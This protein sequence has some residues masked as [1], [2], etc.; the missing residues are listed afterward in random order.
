[1][2]NLSLSIKRNEKIVIVGLSGSGKST[3]IKLLLRLYEP[4]KGSVTIDGKSIY[5][6]SRT[7]LRSLITVVLQD[8]ELFN[9]SFQDNIFLTGKTRNLILFNEAVAKSALN[10][11][12]AGLPQG[13]RTVIGEKGYKLSGGERQRLGLARAIYRDS[14]VIILDEATSQLDSASEELIQQELKQ[15]NDKT[16][17][18]IAHRLATLKHLD[19][20]IYIH[21]GKIIEEGSFKQLISEKGFFYDLWKRQELNQ[22]S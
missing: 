7:S 15:L 16:I 10:K 2:K 21:R 6:Y 8:Q 20:I 17:L 1:M 5:D 12:V 14:P 9:I 11:V 3:L 13:V 4:T 18:V 19:R 22:R